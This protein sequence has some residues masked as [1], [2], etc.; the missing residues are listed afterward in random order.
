MM[1]DREQLS[2]GI[3]IPFILAFLNKFRNKMH[4]VT[5]QANCLVYQIS[6]TDL[7][8]S[9]NFLNKE[10]MSFCEKE[11]KTRLETASNLFENQ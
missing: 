2:H 7:E 3:K 5:S 6:S 4:K 1:T 10:L 11:L 8:D 9:I